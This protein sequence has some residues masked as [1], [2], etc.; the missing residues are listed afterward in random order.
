MKS[1]HK[2]LELYAKIGNSAM[3][4]KVQYILYRIFNFVLLK[5]CNEITMVSFMY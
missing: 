4:Y 1:L 5:K 2:Q 3:L